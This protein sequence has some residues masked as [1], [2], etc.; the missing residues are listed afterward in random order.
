VCKLLYGP[1][2][3]SY[4]SLRQHWIFKQA[5]L[6]VLGADGTACGPKVPNAAY[7]QMPRADVR[8]VFASSVRSS[9]RLSR[10]GEPRRGINSA[11]SPTGMHTATAPRRL[12]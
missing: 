12:G 7:R 2:Y 5:C 6:G 9:E 8:L 3:L 11:K 4:L 1:G 10:V